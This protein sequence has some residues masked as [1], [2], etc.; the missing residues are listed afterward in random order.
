[1][2]EGTNPF[3]AFPGPFPRRVFQCMLWRHVKLSL[4]SLSISSAVSASTLKATTS[5]PGKP[6][7]M[8]LRTRASIRLQ[9]QHPPPTP[10]VTPEEDSIFASK[11][12]LTT[13]TDDLTDDPDVLED[14][15]DWEASP[16]QDGRHE[17]QSESSNAPSDFEVDTPPK[18][19]A[20][21]GANN[22]PK[23]GLLS[24]G[25]TGTDSMTKK[26]TTNAKVKTKVEAHED[27]FGKEEEEEGEVAE[28][29]EDGDATKGKKVTRA[30][31]LRARDA[32]AA[33]RYADFPP[34]EPA[35]NSDKI[36]VPFKG[37][38]GYA[39]L[40][41]ILRARKEPVFCSRTC[42][43]DTIKKEGHGLPFVLEL[44]RQNAAD[45]VK[46]IA[47]NEK[48]GIKFM[49][50][51]SEMFPF[52]SHEDYLY[53]LEHADKELK[54]A[55]ALA[56]KYGHRL[57][58]HPGQF[59]QIA[60]PKPKIFV[61]AERDL[62]FHNELLTRLGLTGQA[63]NDAVMIIHLGGAYGDKPATLDRFRTNYAK[64]SEAV[65]RRLVLENDDMTWSVTDLLPLCQ[66][67]NIPLVLDWHHHN[68]VRDQE[69][70]REGTLDILKLMP[71]IAE[72]WT[73]KG[74]T[75]KQ[76][77]SE[78]KLPNHPS[79]SKRRAHS[80]R[81]YHL[82]PCD[83]TMDLMIE[84]KDKEQ[85]VFELSKVY[86]LNNPLIPPEVIGDG[87]GAKGDEAYYPQGAEARLKTTKTR[88][89]TE[90]YS[91]VTE[92]T[93]SKKTI[94]EDELE[95]KSLESARSRPVR[96]PK[97]SK[98]T[99]EGAQ[100]GEDKKKEDMNAKLPVAAAAEKPKRKLPS[101]RTAT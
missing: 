12:P 40:N 98:E 8:S 97:R 29:E 92:G 2:T 59:T 51:S 27:V 70:F 95:G 35:F 21:S 38:L 53:T 45:L 15:R 86:D 19:K 24:T 36:P 79:A 20:K 52:A 43:L 72:T 94:V 76:H 73:R 1:M 3:F 67:L 31:K 4:L 54:A 22:K 100:D 56:M 55:G 101:K 71:E 10:P 25:K 44:G 84:A 32:L 18:K 96:I 65:K 37:R 66:E 41:T 46:M 90:V 64:L 77:I 13:V 49:R 91:P 28:L 39:C 80:S 17:P 78:S 85:A 63:D 16:D 61:A 75:Q 88:T 11:K 83:D 81:V 60:S 89:K 30:D 57:T 34:R 62:E 48:Y 26:K 14:A 68:I 33:E 87:P 50:I 58:V 9:Q 42:R 99:L 47:W 93:T 69:Q 82:P 6:R 23:N 74:I 5:L 7:F